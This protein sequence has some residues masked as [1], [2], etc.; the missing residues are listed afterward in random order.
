MLRGLEN[1]KIRFKLKL[2]ASSFFLF[3][4]KNNIITNIINLPKNIEN[5]NASRNKVTIELNLKCNANCIFCSRDASGANRGFSLSFEEV[6]NI[7]ET[8]KRSGTRMIEFTG[9]EALLDS[10]LPDYLDYTH[11]LGMQT[12]LITNTLGFSNPILC[13]RLLPKLDSIEMSVPC[14]NENTYN[15][16]T[17]KK[18][19]SQLI[20][21]LNNIKKS[22]CQKQVFI[23]ALK[24]NLPYLLDTLEFFKDF[25]NLNYIS[26]VYPLL[27]GRMHSLFDEYLSF[28][29][30]RFYIIP[31]LKRAKDLGINIVGSKIPLCAFFPYENFIFI[32]SKEFPYK[33]KVIRKYKNEHVCAYREENLLDD[34]VKYLEC[35][36]CIYKDSCLGVIGEYKI[37]FKKIDPITREKNENRSKYFS[38]F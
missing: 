37:L 16:L 22:D 19:Y 24:S 32:N 12:Q 28:S 15:K 11:E 7:I 18:A 13:E 38:K 17:G 9:G 1:L 2:H 10:L 20:T 25:R 5:L 21:A 30:F 6:K 35:K 3:P 33:K 14:V 8:S 31:F 36:E 34:R 26:I 23:I 29:E 4:R 27:E